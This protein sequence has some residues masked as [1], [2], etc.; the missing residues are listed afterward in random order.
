M[1]ELTMGEILMI[2]VLGAI[3]LILL[4]PYLIHEAIKHAEKE[5]N[6]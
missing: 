3:F 1:R 2:P 6:Q 5:K 4:P